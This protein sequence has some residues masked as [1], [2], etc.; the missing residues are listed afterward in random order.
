M[1]GDLLGRYIIALTNLYGVVTEKK[2]VEIYNLHNTPQANLGDLEMSIIGMNLSK[3]LVTRKA[4]YIIKDY[5][6]FEDRYLKQL[7]MQEVRD[8]YIP[9]SEERLQ[10]ED[11]FYFQ[12][13]QRSSRILKYV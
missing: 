5:L 8:Y 3:C 2:V 13:K 11:E 7:E 10:Y 12:K 9:S 1:N 6:I 4:G